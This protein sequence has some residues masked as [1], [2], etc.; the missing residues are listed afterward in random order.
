MLHPVW[1][2]A[3]TQDD[4]LHTLTQ[5]SENP[6][7]KLATLPFQDNTYFRYGTFNR[8]QYVLNIQ[9]VIPFSLTPDWNL[10]TRTILPVMNQPNFYRSHAYSGGIGDLNPT[11]FLSPANPGKVIWG[12][13]PS[14]LFPTATQHDLGAGKWG[15]GPAAVVLGMPGNWVLGA[16]A[17][18]IW[19]F[20]GESNRP[21]YDQLT[22]QYFINYNFPKGWFV[23]SSPIVTADWQANSNDVWTV[24]V[25][26]GFGRVFLM[27]KQAVNTS[28][29]A[30]YNVKQPELT[31][32]AWSV[33]FVFTFLF[34]E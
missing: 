11:F 34:P 16:L 32:P 25:G 2:F 33:R 8:P 27:G 17:Y 3:T 20:A 1:A 28:L 30:F 5:E 4:Q 14:F 6:V 31:G 12:L 18:N 15:A 13:G 23:V 21:T 7:A 9:P 22:L 29:Q 24:P 10:I 26:G 19:S